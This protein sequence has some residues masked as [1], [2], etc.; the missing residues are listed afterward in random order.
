MLTLYHI[1]TDECLG[2]F[3]AD[4]LEQNARGAGEEG[5][6]ALEGRR[7]LMGVE[8][9]GGHNGRVLQ[10]MGMQIFLRKRIRLSLWYIQALSKD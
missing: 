4:L 2:K 8:S 1:D 7:G 9:E 10:Q 5:T 3:D 6:E